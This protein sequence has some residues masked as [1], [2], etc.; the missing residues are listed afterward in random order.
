[1]S[2]KN[3]VGESRRSAVTRTGTL[4]YTFDGD[5]TQTVRVISIEKPQCRAEAA[6]AEGTFQQVK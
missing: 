3:G 5:D 4:Y 6:T 2:V 1:L